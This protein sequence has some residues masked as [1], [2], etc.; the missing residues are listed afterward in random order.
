M[1]LKPKDFIFKSQTSQLESSSFSWSAPSN[2]ALIKY[3]GK[4]D[5]T[6]IIP[7]NSSLS[8]TID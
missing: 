5:E 6:Y 3:W 4:V 8:L 1:M 7:A 2:I